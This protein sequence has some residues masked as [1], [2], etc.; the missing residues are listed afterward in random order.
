MIVKFTTNRK[1][2]WDEFL[3]TS[4]FAYNTAKHE[5]THYTPFELMFGRKA[6]LP[7][8]LDFDSKDGKTLLNE[9]Q[10]SSSG[11]VAIIII[12]V[13]I[14][15][16]LIIVYIFRRMMCPH[17]SLLHDKSLGNQQRI[18]STSLNR[19]KKSSMT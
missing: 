13:R 19:N 8:D 14:Y 15:Y 11:K 5:S 4:V 3:Q 12:F 10:S 6:I 18:I 16:S 2:Q 17:C 7:V 9:Y 1:E